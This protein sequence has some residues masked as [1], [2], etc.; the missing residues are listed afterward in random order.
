[1]GSTA[2]LTFATFAALSGI[3]LVAVGFGNSSWREYIVD[4]TKTVWET[5]INKTA[6]GSS[7]QYYNRTVG[8]FK[9]CFPN[10]YPSENTKV[11][12]TKSPLGNQCT[13]VKYDETITQ[14]QSDDEQLYI[15]LK[16]LY[17][18]LYVVGLFLCFLA[19]L[20]L[21]SG[22]SRSSYALIFTTAILLLF[23]SGFIA[24]GIGCWHKF[25]A[26]MNLLWKQIHMLE[27][28]L[29]IFEMEQHLVMVGLILLLGLELVFF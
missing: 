17:L 20:T 26:L 12:W 13:D 28:G 25:I 7:E 1:M 14:T 8:F 19:I 16:R 6:V 22:C 5:R 9:K 23:A 29:L 27:V 15:H 2:A 24:A 11:T 3:V 21:L 18:S 10:D 4:E